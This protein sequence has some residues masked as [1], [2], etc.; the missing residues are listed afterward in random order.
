[1][2]RVVQCLCLCGHCI[3]GMAYEPGESGST[4]EKAV[5][6]LQKLMQDMIERG[7]CKPA[8]HVCGSRVFHFVDTETSYTTIAE[9]GRELRRLERE[10]RIAADA[11]RN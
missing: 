7:L 8:C 11:R 9:A 6:H 4:A 1:M 2:I 10:R 3:L 5:E